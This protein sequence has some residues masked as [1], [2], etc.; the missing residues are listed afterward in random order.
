MS[1]IQYAKVI[2]GPK[3]KVFDYLTHPQNLESQLK[4]VIAVSWQNTGV[5]V[6]VGS[7][8]LFMMS[9]F[10][11]E[12]PIRFVV[13][14][15]VVG[16]SLTYRQVN[17]VFSRFTHTIRCEEHGQ[18]E[19][20][21]TDLIDYEVPFGLVGRLANDFFVHKDLKHL[22]SHRLEIVNNKFLNESTVISDDLTAGNGDSGK[23]K[24]V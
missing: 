7:E 23:N 2:A 1:H 17:G 15:L 22:L 10:G 11:I 14:K 19:T 4:G 21:V 3:F 12:Q 5:D 18:G 8:F 6:Q 13:D 16:N 9:R 20:L 24:A